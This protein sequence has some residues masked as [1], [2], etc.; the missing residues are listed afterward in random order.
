MNI[1]IIV[2]EIV[3]VNKVREVS[4]G[5]SGSVR[6]L[7]VGTSSNQKDADCECALLYIETNKESDK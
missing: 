2:L 5:K 4:V 3:A 7:W 1:I 6:Q